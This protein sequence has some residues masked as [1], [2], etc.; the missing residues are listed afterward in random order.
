MTWTKTPDDWPD[1]LIEL[2][3]AA[4]RLHHAALTYSNRVGSDGRIHK[5]RLA[6]LPVPAR[7]RRSAIVAE[8]SR[9]EYWID[10]GDSWELRGFLVDQLSAEEVQK[11][12]VYDAVRQR[13]RFAKDDETRAVLKVEEA[14]SLHA[15]ND[16][17]ERRRARASRSD[18]TVTHT[19]PSRSDPTRP[20]PRR[21]RGQEQPQPL[22]PLE[23]LPAAVPEPVC[24][25]CSE[26]LHER[27]WS[28]RKGTRGRL[29]NLHESCYLIGPRNEP[30]RPEEIDEIA[31]R[32]L[33]GVSA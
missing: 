26:T 10:A 12:R 15:L 16:A 19:A 20:V 28:P 8:L 1:Q 23:G 27:A 5:R 32:S 22:R 30:L 24:A 29:V 25:L 6:L 9:L 7:T 31:A 17:R 33:D 11:R 4:Y 21:G 14:E 3:D 2:S 13:I 18:S